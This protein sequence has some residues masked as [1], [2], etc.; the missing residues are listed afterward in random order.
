MEYRLGL[1]ALV[2]FARSVVVSQ[3]SRLSY[4]PSITLNS[5]V[6]AVRQLKVTSNT[7]VINVIENIMGK[8]E[9]ELQIA[10]YY[11]GRLLE[12]VTRKKIE[13]ILQNLREEDL[14]D[15]RWGVYGSTFYELSLI[16]PEIKGV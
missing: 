3:M 13:S 6:R 10:D 14:D 2:D 9:P 1:P 15:V 8:K 11:V 5:A 4:S 16:L 7:F 12:P